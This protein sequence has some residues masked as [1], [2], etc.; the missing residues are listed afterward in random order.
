[1][2]KS[3]KIYFR[4]LS[5]FDKDNTNLKFLE[6]EKRNTEALITFGGQNQMCNDSINYWCIINMREKNGRDMKE[7]QINL[8]F[9]YFNLM[10]WLL[11]EFLSFF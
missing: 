11:K 2:F 8:E 5:F 6:C 9:F 1:M 3:I 7:F 10:F 4:V